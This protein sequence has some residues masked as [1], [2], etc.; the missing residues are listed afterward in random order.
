MYQ[1]WIFQNVQS[2]IFPKIS[3]NIPLRMYRQTPYKWWEALECQG[4]CNSLNSFLISIQGLL[5]QILI[6]IFI[7]LSRLYSNYK[8]CQQNTCLFPSLPF[9]TCWKWGRV[10]TTILTHIPLLDDNNDNNICDMIKGNESDVVNINF[11]L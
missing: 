5:G 7:F 10:N 2:Y 8:T 11:E 4:Y 9:V 3:S 1:S 6:Q